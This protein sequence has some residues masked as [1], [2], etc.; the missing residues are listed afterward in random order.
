MST[1]AR[2]RTGRSGTPAPPAPRLHLDDIDKAL[3]AELQRN[4]RLTYQELGP[5]V[6]LSPPAVRQRVQ[7]LISS[8]AVQVVAVTDPLTLGYPVMAMVGLRS[9][10]DVVAT[11]DAIADIE[12]VIYIVFTTGS[13]DLFAEV[14]CE[15]AGT[16][17]SIVNDR[18]KPLP[19][20]R[21]VEIFT[22]LAI[23]TH[24]FTWG[25]R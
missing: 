2:R 9:D 17:L 13:F 25:V 11:A 24:R 8:G 22:E 4:G 14:L 16:L 19:G 23:H 21:E 10:G 20:V 18:I 5:R 1:P 3:I 12:G 7:R 6:G 15:D